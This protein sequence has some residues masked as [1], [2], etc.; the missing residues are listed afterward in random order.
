[1]GI[2]Q[3]FNHTPDIG[4]THSRTETSHAHTHSATL[5]KHAL[6]PS[7]DGM[8]ED[9]HLVERAEVAS[10]VDVLGPQTACDIASFTF[11]AEQGTGA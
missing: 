7:H 5:L 3:P 9:E 11:F 8:L 10:S 4:L 1:M 2:E 6:N